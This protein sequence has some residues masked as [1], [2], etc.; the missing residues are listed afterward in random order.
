MNKLRAEFKS[1]C[2]GRDELRWWKRSLEADFENGEQINKTKYQKI[3]R[4]YEDREKKAWELLDKLNQSH[5]RYI[6]CMPPSFPPPP[7]TP[8]PIERIREG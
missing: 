2:K 3:C 6:E 7:P 8:S 4:L 5:P 1:Y